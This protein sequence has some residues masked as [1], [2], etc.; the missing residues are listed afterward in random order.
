[1]ASRIGEFLTG[2][3]MPLAQAMFSPAERRQMTNFMHL[4]QQLE[5]RQGTVNYSNTAPVLRQLTLGAFKNIMLLIGDAVAGPAGAL[6]GWSARSVADRLVERSAAGRVARS[7][8]Q[9]P[10][11]QQADARFGEQM[12]RY[13]AYASRLLTPHP[14]GQ[15]RDFHPSTIGARRAP[16]GE[17]YLPDPTRPGQYLR[18]AW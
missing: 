15:P 8:Y 2:S 18:V 7:L 9:T 17:H 6:A 14:D 12:G 10:A 13:G 5:P 4:Q 3:G 16:D 1:M 11:R